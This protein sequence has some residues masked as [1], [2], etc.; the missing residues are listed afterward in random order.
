MEAERKEGVAVVADG[1]SSEEKGMSGTEMSG[2]GWQELR[3]GASPAD[4]AEL[5]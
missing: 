3:E 2:Q 5:K 4:P 1:C